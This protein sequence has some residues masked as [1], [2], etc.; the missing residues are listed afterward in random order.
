MSNA[1]ASQ[2]VVSVRLNKPL[3]QRLDALVERTGRSRGFYLRAAIESLLPVLEARYWA[4][5]ATDRA[6]QLDQQFAALIRSLVDDEG[7]GLEPPLDD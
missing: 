7:A 1:K 5:E 4:H 3:V 6:D 2:P